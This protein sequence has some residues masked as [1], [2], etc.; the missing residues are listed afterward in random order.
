M[1]HNRKFT[2]IFWY[3]SLFLNILPVI[4]IA[5]QQIATAPVITLVNPS[6]PDSLNNSGI[7]KVRAEIVSAVPLNTIRIFNNGIKVVSESGIKPEKKDNITYVIESLVPLS[8]GSNIIYVEV[9]NS[10]GTTSS[11]KRSIACQPEPFVTWILPASVSTTTYSEMLP[12]KA[13]I[14]TDFDLKSISLNINGTVTN[15]EIEGIKHLNNNTY[16][17]EKKIQLKP[18]KNSIYITAGNIKG[19]SGS[20]TRFINNVSGSPLITL[21]SPSV[22]DSLN[23]SGLALVKAEIISKSALQ[24]VS[25][26]NNDGENVVSE[27]AITPEQK[28]SGKYIIESLVPLKGGLNI[29]YLE[30]K[31]PIGSTSSERR[32]ITCQPE[33]FVTWIVPASVTSTSGSEILTVK[34][35]I[36]TDFD[37]KN[38][39]INLNGTVLADEKE[40]ITRLSDN[41]YSFERKILLKSGKNS[42]FIAADNSKGVANSTTRFVNN[43]FGSPVITILSPDLT[44]S[45]N[46]SGLTL[47]RAQIFS[48]SELQ[49][50]SIFNNDGTN[51]VSEATIKPV[52]KDSV[53]YL[54]ESLFPLKGGLNIIY[55]EAKNSVASS[56]SE[57]RRITCQP[58][59]FITW[60]LPAYVNS[61]A[62][63]EMLTIKAEIKTDIDL[64]SISLN[65]NGIVL[66]QESEGITRLNNNTYVLERKVQLKSGKNSIYIS[67]VNIKGETIS[68]TRIINNS[69]GSAP[70]ITL[71]NPSI[72][73]SLNNSGL[74]L[75]SA[76]IVS[77]SG[78]QTVRIF[79]NKTM[80]VNGTEEILEHKDS[81]TY[82][83]KNLVPLQAGINT[84]YIEAKNSIGTA[85]SEKRSIICQLEPIIN[86]ILPVSVSSTMGSG[87]MNIKAEIMTSFDLIST[88][89]NLNG[90]VIARD[91][92]GIIRLNNNTYS[93]EKSVSLNAGANNIILI[94]SNAKGTAYSTKR[95]VNYV[96]DITS[97]IKRTDLIEA[98]SN[99]SKPALP[100][101]AWNNPISD[102]QVV[103]KPSIDIEMNIKSSADLENVSLYLNGKIPDN[104]NSVINVKKEIEGFVLRKTVTLTPGEN[105]IYVMAGNIAGKATSETRSIKYIVPSMP[106]ITWKNPDS[107]TSSLASGN[108]TIKVNITSTTDL[109]NLKVFHN[110]QVLPGVPVVNIID[111]QQGEYQ[112]EK[113]ITL[114]Q[115]ENRLYIVAENSAGSST[116]ETRSVNYMVP[117]AP[118]VIWVSPSRP[119][120][121]INLN[122]AKIK[123]TIKSTDKPQSLLVY[124]NGVASEEVNQISPA[125]SQGEYMLEKTINL[126]PGENN[127]Y[128]VATNNNGTTKSE[129]RYLTNPP[130]NPPVISWTNPSDPNVIVNSELVVI[131]A[132]IK[133]ATELKL[134]QIFVN[135][136]QQAS[137]MMFQAA[138]TGDCNYI[139]T[140]PVILKEGDNSVFII[141]TNF[142]GSINSDKR[143]I[144]FEK[145]SLVE[146]RLALVIGNSD[147]GN[148][149]ILKN[150][151]N[152]A[153]LIEGT[154]KTLGFNVIKRTNASKTEMY[155]ALR[156]FSKK[157]PEYNVALFYYAGHGVQVDGQNYLVPIDAALKEQT[158]CKWEAMRVND[159]VEEFEKVPENINIVI[160]DA[161]R[162][163]PFRSWSRGGAQGFRAINSVSGTIISFA[164]SEGSTA[165]DGLGS[166]GTFT[167][168]LV[169]Q[170]NIP[171][172]LSSVFNNTR[173]QV[174]K[175]TNNSQ[176]PLEMNGLT[177]DFYFK[178]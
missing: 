165:A 145:A 31:N 141:A 69:S 21:I 130:A 175:R 44:D 28:D 46:N 122:S 123:V 159:I 137:E 126:L 23:N 161:C 98:N 166:N 4:P 116:S 58:E 13:E 36:K 128:L 101:L 109:Q 134:A 118:V 63:S 151:V 33:P 70:A 164:T 121:E 157:L 17:F 136:V 171:Q 107:G 66:V 83:M 43:S 14:K 106:V 25:I 82:G 37:L 62:E 113:T 45:L 59:P 91:N 88:S 38:I 108:L 127:I 115:G 131:E 140:R 103:N 96:P 173:K 152:D 11:E 40:G 84:I 7:T 97:E 12:V 65:L 132:C 174:M 16:R 100:V 95:T 163:N 178:K 114:N 154:L 138:Q 169:K 51:V 77:K 55:L 105:T 85:T 112:I 158:D 41:T 8:R 102:Q 3:V 64:K 39:S 6:S 47:V 176:R 30:A 153:N 94:V 99:S 160:L 156:E 71:I 149:N 61:T 110:D 168:E 167:E 170:M 73:D 80:V 90:N 142:A 52:K 72:T 56:G 67:A 54:I 86:W 49:T 19:A 172:S 78:L 76:E 148:S 117:A 81:T 162:N 26:I 79:N 135:G 53:T 133:S 74:A 129:T 20:T 50:V 87:I 124:S 92:E 18:G 146:K 147:Y 150:P 2:A 10:I 125:G 119:N 144:R 35:E 93:I 34:A 9:K 89:I 29:I 32:R 68:T 22:M 27:T 1:N 120:I 139:L 60:L 15:Q 57:K 143:L 177:G 5:G 75:V 48:K 155:E 104:E 111:K 42:I 24:T